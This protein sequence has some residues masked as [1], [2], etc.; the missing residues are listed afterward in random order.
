MSLFKV[1][2]YF[3]EGQRS[4][5]ED[6]VFSQDVMLQMMSAEQFGYWERRGNLEEVRADLVETP[7]PAPDFAE[8]EPH[9]PDRE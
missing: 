2:F 4:Y 9:D 3:A 6:E 5:H 1:R 7:D 8:P